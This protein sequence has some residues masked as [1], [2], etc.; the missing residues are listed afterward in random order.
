MVAGNMRKVYAGTSARR[1]VCVHMTANTNRGADADAHAR[2]QLN[3]GMPNASWHVQVDDTRA[4]QSYEWTARTWHAGPTAADWVAVE[5]CVN[6]D[7][8]LARAIANGAAVVRGILDE[9]GLPANGDTVKQH[10]DFMVK[11]CPREIRAG[12]GGGWAGFLAMVQGAPAKAG[13]APKHPTPAA[14]GS[15]AEL[16]AA[17][18][19]GDY[20]AGDARREALGGQYAAVQAEVNRRL[21][22]GGGTAPKVTPL[23]VLVQEV[24]DGKHGNGAQRKEALGARY[25][26]VQAEVNRRL[27]LGGKTAQ[28]PVGQIADEVIR[29]LWG[30]DPTRAQRLAAAGYDAAAVQREVNRRVA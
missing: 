28:R 21:G 2:L 13:P 19:R 8:N 14:S 9:L 30:N 4:I 11:N 6:S 10:A 17:V 1:G 15:V 3:G 7:G 23:G 22:F 20:G 18:I 16:A 29:G 25:S 26:E 5:I 12:A 24:M 27:G